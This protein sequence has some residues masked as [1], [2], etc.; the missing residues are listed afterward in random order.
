[1]FKIFDQKEPTYDEAKKF[2]GGYIQSV[3]L[4]NDDRL[5][6][7]EEGKL[8]GL[9]PNPEAQK[10]WEESYGKTDVMVGPCILVKASVNEGW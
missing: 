6:C 1:M 7:D 10:H 3:P 2:I 5:L 4:E 9:A 8:K